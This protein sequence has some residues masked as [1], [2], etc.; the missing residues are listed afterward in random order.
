MAKIFCLV[1]FLIGCAGNKI[2]YNSPRKIKELSNSVVKVTTIYN[3]QDKVT[4]SIVHK[5]FFATGFSISNTDEHSYVLT[6]QHVCDMR[7]KAAYSLTLTNGI[8][9]DAKY[10]SI[11]PFADICLL[12]T[13]QNIPKVVLAENNAVRGDR[14]LTI[15]GPDG[16]FPVITDGHISG[17]YN[18]HMKKDSEEDDGEFEVNFRCQLMSAPIYQGSSGSPV[19]DVN[20]EVVGIVFAVRDRQ[21]I[22]EHIVFIVPISEVIRFLDRSEYIY[23]N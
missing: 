12:K 21:E 15:G 10:V 20:G 3:I 22:K 7:D 4:L 6:N 16:V 18:I 19:F 2:T 14:V 1:I 17:Y 13:K 11:D 9:V 8:R 23:V 5:T